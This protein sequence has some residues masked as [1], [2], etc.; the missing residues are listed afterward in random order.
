MGLQSI[1]IIT[2]ADRDGKQHNGEM[3]II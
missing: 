2:A 3:H 1:S